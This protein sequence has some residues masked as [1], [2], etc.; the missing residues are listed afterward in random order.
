MR[1]LSRRR[2]AVVL[3]AV[4]LLAACGGADDPAADAGDV[5]PAAEE[6]AAD[7][8]AA[9]D[10][11]A[12]APAGEVTEAYAT[13]PARSGVSTP[14][15][16]S[17]GKPSVALPAEDPTELVVIDVTA[18]EGR[19]AEIGDTVVFDYVGV[20]SADG[21]EFD[22]SYDRGAPLTV[23][24]GTTGL[25]TGFTQGLI[26]VQAGMV[27]QLDIPASLAYGD[28]GAGGL[29]PPGAAISFVLDIRSVE[30]PLTLGE[31]ADPADCPPVDGSGEQIQQFDAYPPT[32]IDVT[33]AYTAEI[34][35]NF[36]T[37]VAELD[38]T[39][40]PLT[41]NNFV[42]LARYRYFD[43]TECH[44]AIPGFVVQCGDPTATGTGGPGYRFP[45]ELPEP[46]E[47][48]IGSLAMANSG[49]D[50]NGSQFF[51]VT[52]QSGAN[53]PPN[54]TLFGQV[55]DGIDSTL[56]ALDAVANPDSNGVPP[57]EQ[58][59]IESVTIIES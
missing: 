59:I 9:D 58:I 4:A 48:R 50:T 57:L 29:I 36:G 37:V 30:A 5:D 11:A 2:T 15:D 1:Y 8:T 6:P 41:V 20:L 31:Q 35:T 47:Y 38:P 55:I 19:A 42:T 43:G 27:R 25:I 44:R 40:A 56:P 23:T 24:I 17:S 34:V 52:G 14:A 51:I 39:K 16:A 53:L 10:T 13:A 54:Y 28:T 45:D 49:P 33:K 7:D 18:G 32:C 3:A 21:S 46:G 12:D 26:G 22:N